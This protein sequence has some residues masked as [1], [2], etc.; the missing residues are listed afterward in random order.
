MSN[1]VKNYKLSIKVE[2]SLCK[3]ILLTKTSKSSTEDELASQGI[4]IDFPG[5]KLALSNDNGN[6]STGVMAEMESR[7]W[8]L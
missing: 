8:R 3:Q 6:Q 5:W 7:K 4:R 1:T 2:K